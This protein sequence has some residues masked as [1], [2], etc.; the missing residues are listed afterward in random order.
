MSVMV[1]QEELEY[2]IARFKAREA[3]E[4][5]AE[6]VPT[7]PAVGSAEDEELGDDAFQ[8]EDEPDELQSYAQP[9]DDTQGEAGGEGV[10][11][12]VQ[13]ISDSSLIELG[14]EAYD[15]DRRN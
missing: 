9:F 2:A 3:G 13:S 6:A 7:A 1:S 14:D 15:H 5:F 11:H 4:E 8:V 12:Q 10:P